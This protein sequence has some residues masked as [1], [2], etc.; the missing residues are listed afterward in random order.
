M[1]SLRYSAVPDDCR[2]DARPVDGYR[3]RYIAVWS[4]GWVAVGG[5]LALL[6][7]T[8]FWFARQN[9]LEA[10]IALAG[11]VVA[12]AAFG[13]MYRTPARIRFRAGSGLC[14]GIAREPSS[15]C[16]STL[17]ELRDNVQQARL[18]GDTLSVVGAAWSN[19]LAQRT[20]RGRRLYMH[21][22][23][24]SVADE[25]GRV[26]R[27]WLAGTSLKIVQQSL[28]KES[29][30]LIGVPSS[31]FVTIGAWVAT[32]CHGCSGP[33]SNHGMILARALVLDQL[34]GVEVDVG[35]ERLLDMFGNGSVRARQY[36][37]LTVTIG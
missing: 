12:G 17:A 20:V 8:I 7:L 13:L 29:L 4:V 22:M 25:R 30:Q 32:I 6:T 36:V 9:T 10:V 35:P 5:A 33:N 34:I 27:T 23:T 31:S 28:A 16:P 26:G 37:V 2:H 1:Q 21:C 15:F 19:V 3:W 11:T 24:G 18:D 14:G